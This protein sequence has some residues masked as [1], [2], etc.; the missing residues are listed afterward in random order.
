MDDELRSTVQNISAALLEADRPLIITGTHS[1]SRQMLYAASNIAQA[2]SKA[3]KTPSLF[4]I[5]PEC[6]SMGLAMMPGNPLEDVIEKVKNGEIEQVIILENDLY[7]R[8]SKDQADIL[9][10]LCKRVIVIDHLENESTK[11]ADILLPAGTF[12]ESEGSLVNNEGR[13]QRFYSILPP[14]RAVIESWRQIR[15]IMRTLGIREADAW[16]SFDDIVKAMTDAFPAFA[17]IRSHLPN[18][19]FRLLNE[20]IKRQTIRYSGRTAILANVNVSEPKVPDDPDSPLAFTME[21]SD[22]KP[23]SSLVSYYWMPG[24]NSYQ[25]MNFYMDEPNG[26]MK[27]GDPGIRLLQ[28]EG[29]TSSPFYPSEG[30]PFTP[31]PGK[32]MGFPV[33]HIFGSEELSSSGKTLA[34][35]IQAPFIFLNEHDAEGL[36]ARSNDTLEFATGKY[37]R[38][39]NLHIENSIPDGVAGFS[40]GLPGSS[41][42]ELPAQGSL[43]KIQQ[44]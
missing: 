42:L 6:N 15:N 10:N 41:Y 14:G 13:A 36:G 12:A 38:Q 29:S 37:T 39:F 43:K 21:G 5:L 8:V 33:Y 20:K 2:L 4:V 34:L 32:W 30:M 35:R 3:G 9:F 24:W 26:S 1:G 16:E 11:R 28:K 40:T 22:E 19:D 27:G 17:P 23:P 18:A 44:P 31:E 25:A 7:R